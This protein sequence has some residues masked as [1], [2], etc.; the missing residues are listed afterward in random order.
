V[1]RLSLPALALVSLCFLPGRLAIHAYRSAASVNVDVAVLSSTG[2]PVKGLTAADF[3]I[4][5]D[6]EPVPIASFTPGPVPL[7]V[8]LLID[9]SGS[10]RWDMRSDVKD[11]AKDEVN[12]G[13]IPSVRPTD[14]IRIGSVAREIFISPS[15]AKSPQELKRTADRA[16]AHLKDA[17][18]PS[19]L[20]DALHDAIEA[21][22][23]ED[24]RRAVILISDGRASGNRRSFQEIANDGVES[25]VLINVGGEDTERFIRQSLTEAVVVRSGVPMQWIAQMT[26][27]L[28]MRD[29][30]MLRDFFKETMDAMRVMYTL[31][32]EAP[33]L[34]GRFHKLEIRVKRAD[35]TAR[36]RQ[37]YRAPGS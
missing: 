14:R 30:T 25:G 18:G 26:G 22:A 3:S 35:G 7:N 4:L 28:Q 37:M 16:L 12:E 24:G 9:I 29:K 20:W 27:G 15:I 36:A 5:S 10:M 33:V 31:T 34:D 32:F 23:G 6:G 19:P 17:E 1:R 13:F 11:D 2:A 8:V 21:L